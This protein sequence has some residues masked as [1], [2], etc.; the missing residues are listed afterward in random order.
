MSSV[1]D[2][3]TPKWAQFAD[4][5]GFEHPSFRPL[6]LRD[7]DDN[8]HEFHFRSLLLGDQLSLEAFELVGDD[9]TAGYRFQI[10]GE[11]ES[12]P[13]ALLGRLVQKMKR[14][15]SMKHLEPD[16][17][18]LLIANTTVRGR[19]EWNGEEHAPQPCVMI[20][21]RRIEW[22]DLGAMLLAFEGWQ[23]RLEMLDPSDEA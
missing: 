23:F 1:A 14:A 18:R 22:N 7:V 12:E 3:S 2:A 8:D 16:A 5:H 11:A 6:R 21:G 9:E 13:F 10:L 20:D 15:L 19:I 17:G 4:L